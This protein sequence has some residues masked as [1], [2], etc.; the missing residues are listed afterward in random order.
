MLAVLV[1]PPRQCDTSRYRQTSGTHVKE[2]RGSRWG[3]SGAG[4]QAW[5]P[6]EPRCSSV[7]QLLTCSKWLKVERDEAL[8]FYKWVTGGADCACARLEVA[9]R[10]MRE[11]EQLTPC[12][13]P[14]LTCVFGWIQNLLIWACNFILKEEPLIIFIEPQI[15]NNI[16]PAVNLYWP[17][18]A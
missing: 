4:P 10:R 7:P 11:C 18:N 17:Q 9:T 5:E 15:H 14:K 3:L 12:P 6:A 13:P 8:R 2:P 16:T 1:R